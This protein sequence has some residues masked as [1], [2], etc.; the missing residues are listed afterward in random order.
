MIGEY[1]PYLFNALDLSFDIGKIVF[2]T[3]LEN[4]LRYRVV[5]YIM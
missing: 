1:N 2:I 4:R 3:L 5:P